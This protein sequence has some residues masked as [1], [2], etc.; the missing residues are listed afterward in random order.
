M[1]LIVRHAAIPGREGLCDIAVQ[2]GRIAAIEPHLPQRAARELDAEGNLVTPGLVETHIHLDAALTVGQP[3]HNRSGSLF[4]GIEIWAER[5]RTLTE[6]DVRTRALAALRWMLAHG[7]TRV[8]T[9]VDI[10]DPQLTALRALL[11]VREEVADRI[12]LQ[13]VAFPQQGIY[14]FPDG[15]R[16][17]VQALE[18]GA[19]VVGGIPHY[20]WTREYGERDVKTALRLAAEYDRPADLHCDETD[21]DQSRFLEVVAAETI[22]LGLQ[23]RVTASHTT[24]MHSYN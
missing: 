21:D 15:E 11:E 18:M 12:T 24:A 20:E 13:L 8:R 14:S 19:D 23:G 7:V 16:L 17:L 3:R 2:D 9:H 1:D 22:R 6:E 5:V 10:C 4:E